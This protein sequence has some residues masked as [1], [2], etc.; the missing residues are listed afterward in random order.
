MG[1]PEL[2]EAPA[3]WP[4]R[5]EALR[6]RH[7]SIQQRL[8]EL[9][10]L[11]ARPAPGELALARR[12][13]LDSQLAARRARMSYRDALYRAALAHDRAAAA[14]QRAARAT[15]DVGHEQLA[16]SHRAAAAADRRRAGQIQI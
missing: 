1:H 6:R 12:R 8:A 7:A 14:Y 10:V 5:T 2:V 16:V 13:V 11:P 15:G 9:A 3:V 4:L